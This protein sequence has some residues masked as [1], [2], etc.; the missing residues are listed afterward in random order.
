MKEIID[1]LQAV[2]CGKS[3]ELSTSE[4]SEKYSIMQWKIPSKEKFLK[5]QVLT[6]TTKLLIWTHFFKK[7]V[8]GCPE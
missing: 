1:Y 6:E 2:K 3:K 4:R 8:K 7:E 5:H